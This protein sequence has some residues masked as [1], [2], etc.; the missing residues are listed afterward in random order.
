MNK[1]KERREPQRGEIAVVDSTL[2]QKWTLPGDVLQDLQDA[3]DYYDSE[4][5]GFIKLNHFRNILH[6]FGFHKLSK[7]E[8]DDEL[9]RHDQQFASRLYIPFDFVRT[10]VSYRY[11]HKNGKDDEALECWNLFD[12]RGKTTITASELKSV[13]NI[14]LDF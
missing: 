6:N 4:Q 9:K 3:F 7:K 10:A 13:L 14:Y 8:I 12:K 5:D 11:Q 1:E 2:A